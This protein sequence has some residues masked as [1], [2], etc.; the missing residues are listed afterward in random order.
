MNNKKLYKLITF[1]KSL[2]DDKLLEI[3]SV[4]DIGN[5]ISFF[6]PKKNASTMNSNNKKEYTLS[7]FVSAY[8]EKGYIVSLVDK[9]NKV[10]KENLSKTDYPTIRVSNLANNAMVVSPDIFKGDRLVAK[11][12]K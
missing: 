11:K 10:V 3:M 7:D 8:N 12:G 9:N 5:A 1:I 4:S 6:K 2:P